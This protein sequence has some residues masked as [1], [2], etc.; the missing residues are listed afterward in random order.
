MGTGDGTEEL[1]QRLSALEDALRAAAAALQD[2][3]ARC[4][5]LLA[6]ST[7]VFFRHDPAWREMHLLGGGDFL[8]DPGR[9]DPDWLDRH[10]PRDEQPR[11]RAAI[12]EAVR[13]RRVFEL[14]HRIIR[15][16]GSIG[17]ALSRS[18]PH[19]DAS[20]RIAEWFGIATDVTARHEAEAALREGELR[21]AFLLRLSDAVRLLTDAG[22]IRAVACRLV[23]EQLGA[24]RAYYVEYDPRGEYGSVVGD[25]ARNGLPSLAG[26]YP[27]EAFRTTYDRIADGETWVVSDMTRQDGIAAA[28]RATYAAQGVVAWVD[29]PLLKSGR[30]EAVLCVVQAAARAWTME[31]VRLVQETAERLRAAIARGRVEAALRDSEARF[32]QF[33]EASS[34]ALWVRDAATLELEYAS[35]AIAGIHGVAADALL[36]DVRR[37]GA[38]VV[39]EDRSLA[40]RGI[41]QAGDGM[42][43]VQEFRIQRSS[44]LVFRWI[45]ST[46]FPLFDAA[47]RVE[48]IGGITEDVT[49]SR[50]ADQHR[51]VLL[52]EL[53]HRVRNIMAI[54][55][56]IAARTAETAGSVQGYAEA[57][58]GRLLTLARVQALLTR[59]ANAGV[60]IA[61]IVRDELRAQAPHEAQFDLRGPD[62]MLSPKTAEVLTLAVHE[63]A[64]NAV[65]H[66]AFS[67]PAGE[68]RVRWSVKRRRGASRLVFDWTET[69]APRPGA[70]PPRKG[71]GTE[72]IEGR[73]PYELGGRGSVVIGAGGAHCHMEFPLTHGN[74]VLETDAP[75]PAIAFGG[76]LDMAGEADLTGHRIL[77]VEDEF[78][79]ATDTARAIRGAG[80]EVIGP[81]A[82]TVA[83]LKELDVTEPTGAIIDIDLAAGRSYLLARTLRERGIPFVFVS[84]YDDEAI[85]AEFEDV[86]RLQKPVE[87]RR[88]VNLLAEALQG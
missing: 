88:A 57:I 49:E 86:R 80:A 45:R 76:V 25:H 9:P 31:E 4:R 6:A 19:F 16:D 41:E 73:I 28:E 22:E 85:P 79:L 15:A 61:D 21:Q 30:L 24:D 53:Q 32:S 70:T 1:R 66:G 74:S 71:F 44:D 52:A 82:Q 84:G 26:R 27:Y 67:T 75:P 62:V 64:T 20:G 50:L 55:R 40:L 63:L 42:A 51:R 59:A 60:G 46:S 13:T 10:I 58:A 14:E 8:A 7:D 2:S 54:I 12:A 81:C 65:K 29:V 72:L 87:L 23:A 69:G 36:G 39:P 56:A 47:G 5:D 38:L 11:V 78:Y 48:R 34:A 17:W 18:T 68:V 37:W 35:P 3:E 33:A 77:V 43:G 83:A